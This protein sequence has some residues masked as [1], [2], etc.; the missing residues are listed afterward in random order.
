MKRLFALTI[1]IILLLTAMPVKASAA[2]MTAS[3]KI[4]AF[5]KKKESFS[6]YVTY[7]HGKPYIAYGNAVNPADYPNGISYEDA[8]KLMRKDVKIVE[9][10]LNAFLTKRGITV[11]QNQFDCLVSFTYSSGP[12]WLNSESRFRTILL[13]GPENYTAKQTIDAIAVWCHYSGKIS[14]GLVERR[15]EEA[16]IF[17]Y[18]DYDF[19]SSPDWKYVI[20]NAGEGTC[21]TDIMFYQSGL[22]Y[23]ELQSA[24]L[25]GYCLAGWADSSGQIIDPS[26]TVVSNKRVTAVWKTPETVTPISPSTP[27][28]QEPEQNEEPQ[29]LFKDVVENAWYYRYVSELAA[30]NIIKGY[31]DGTFRP[32]GTVTYGESLCLILKAAGYP[33]QPA[34]NAEHWA[35]GYLA[36]AVSEGIVEQGQIPDL[37]AS[38]PR[39][40][41]ARIC[42]KALKIRKSVADTP[43]SD[44]DDP[45]LTALYEHNIMVGNEGAFLPDD[46]IIRSE[47]STVIWKIVFGDVHIGQTLINGEWVTVAESAELCKYDP[48]LFTVIDGMASYDSELAQTMIGIDVSSYQ[49]PIEWSRVKDSG[50]EF[51]LIRAGYRG[52]TEGNIYP[53]VYFEANAEGAAL[54]EIKIGVYFFSQALT[55]EEAEQEALFVI[56]KIKDHD[57]AMPVVFDWE[58]IGSANARTKDMTS[59]EITTC[60]LKFCETIE[61][62]GYRPMIYCNAVNAYELYDF[63]KISGIPV[64]LAQ[65]TDRPDF[66]YDFNVWQYTDKGTVDGIMTSVDMDLFI[67]MD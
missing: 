52:Y 11:T 22:P 36:L 35:S 49:G 4:I 21:D 65:L 51:A 41:I 46:G 32:D 20:Y 25:S 48:S 50:I 10:E 13:N 59:D 24:E 57:I 67:T 44:A 42:A 3:E 45:Y 55:A 63:S 40:E 60:A 62:A 7:Y 38:A 37:D 29:G 17:Y 6:P 5:I 15:V 27:T 8:D 19:D 2:G 33:A 1:A 23:G 14:T 39:I 43:F 18:G 26:Q 16:R 56:E 54:A 47:I 53:D 34:G 9:G 66:Y 28:P 58:T 64:W 30:E 31:E 12:A 61:N